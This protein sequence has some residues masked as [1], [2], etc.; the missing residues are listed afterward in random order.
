M[1]QSWELLLEVWETVMHETFE[2]GSQLVTARETRNYPNFRAKCNCL[3]LPLAKN[4]S[5]F[6]R[7]EYKIHVLF[8]RLVQKQ[9]VTLARNWVGF[10]CDHMSNFSF[11]IW[12]LHLCQISPRHMQHYSIL[13]PLHKEYIEID[14]RNNIL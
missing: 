14:P 3:S 6:D 10:F 12:T 8:L 1:G 2:R 5:F 7:L 4:R 11:L 9:I 13:S